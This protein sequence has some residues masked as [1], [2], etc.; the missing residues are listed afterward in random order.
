MENKTELFENINKT[1]TPKET[2]VLTSLLMGDNVIET[3]ANCG[4]SIQDAAKLRTKIYKICSDLG[5]IL[6]SRKTKQADL[7]EQLKGMLEFLTPDK[8]AEKENEKTKEDKLQMEIDRLV[9]LYEPLRDEYFKDL[10]IAQIAELAKKTIRLTDEIRRLE[11]F[12]EEQA[13]RIGEPE[14]SEQSFKFIE[15]AIT[16]AL[17]CDSKIPEI[18]GIK[19]EEPQEYRSRE[20]GNFLVLNPKKNAPNR[21]YKYFASAETAAKQVAKKE[22]ETTYVL[23]IEKM[24]VPETSFY[25]HDF[26]DRIIAEDYLTQEIPF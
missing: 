24:I 11:N 22:Q 26:K 3:A 1:L 20:H 15:D 14:S 21:I 18:E 4:V 5:V 2:E 12:I 10:T 25:V 7:I 6:T 8:P 13:E 19:K 17:D 16:K 9:E 23:R